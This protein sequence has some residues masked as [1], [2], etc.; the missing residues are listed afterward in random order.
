MKTSFA[1]AVR[2]PLLVWA[3]A[4]AAQSLSPGE[5]L[6]EIPGFV[7]EGRIAG[8]EAWRDERAGD[9]WFLAP[10]GETIIV[11]RAIGISGAGFSNADHAGGAG[12]AKTETLIVN[13]RGGGRA[14]GSNSEPA[15]ARRM[16][17]SSPLE[18]YCE[19]VKPEGG[20]S[21]DVPKLSRVRDA[22]EMSGKGR[23]EPSSLGKLVRLRQGAFWF[24][25]GHPDSPVVYALVDPACPYSAE[26][27]RRLKA[28]V[29]SGSL[30]LRIVLLETS[31]PG[32]ADALAAILSQSEP[33][34]AFWEHAISMAK[35][36]LSKLRPGDFNALPDA[37]RAAL[38][39]NARL[40]AELEIPG[41]PFFMFETSLGASVYSGVPGIGQF[42]SALP[43]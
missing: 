3:S 15:A 43:E 12:P 23:I 34:A 9:F 30:Q 39:A 31:R 37:V 25:T 8:M 19:Y 1:L 11:G 5:L 18:D 7:R 2:V 26:A 16:S 41:V 28:R 42:D 22:A 20:T 4:T 13:D 38:H 33:P 35:T 24:G 29:D 21:G 40:A 17:A 6:D 14:G 36:G 10:D 32:S 27:M